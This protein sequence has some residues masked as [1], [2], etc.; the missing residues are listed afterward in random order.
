MPHVY[1]AVDTLQ[2]K[3]LVGGGDCVELVKAFAPGLIGMPTSMWRP[4]AKVK[5]VANLKRGTAIATFVD[6]KY[7]NNRSGQH[8]AF[9][10]KHAGA[11]I[12]AMDQWRGDAKRP[13][14]SKRVIAAGGPGRLYS[15]L[16]NNSQ[17][18]YVI[19]LK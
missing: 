16:S 3:E 11:G 14:V 8:A 18:F 13:R 2:N 5:D 4:G 6:G 19:E 9:F 12:W 17:A 15:S 10:L 1:G 7:P